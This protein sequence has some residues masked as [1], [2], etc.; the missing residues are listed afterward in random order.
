M[1]KPLDSVPNGNKSSWGGRRAGA[2]RKRDRHRAEM[3]ALMPPYWSDRTFARWLRFARA[4]L[5]ETAREF[6]IGRAKRRNGSISVFQLASFVPMVEALCSDQGPGDRT[7]T[8]E[9]VVYWITAAGEVRRR[10]VKRPS[11]KKISSND[12]R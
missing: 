3:R 9:G 6:A 2:G 7:F 1:D 12:T 8:V 10:V 11:N 5:S 4:P